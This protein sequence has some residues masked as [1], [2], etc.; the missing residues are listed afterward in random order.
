MRHAE[1]VDQRVPVELAA[2]VSV[3]EHA[4]GDVPGQRDAA[5]L[6]RELEEHAQLNRA[7]I[8]H[9]VDEHVREPDGLRLRVEE[10]PP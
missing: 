8:L 3:F 6:A 1:P 10:R 4:L 9:L 5:V 7:R 2:V